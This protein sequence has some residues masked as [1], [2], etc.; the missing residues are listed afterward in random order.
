MLYGG[1]PTE[2]LKEKNIVNKSSSLSS[3]NRMSLGCAHK[4]LY[5]RI[6]LL[7]ATFSL[8]FLDKPY[9]SMAVQF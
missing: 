1:S 3:K 2:A 7:N 8:S 9:K 5:M 4:Q 6:N